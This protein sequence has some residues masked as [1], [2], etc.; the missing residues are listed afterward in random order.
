MNPAARWL[1]P[2]IDPARREQCLAHLHPDIVERLT[3]VDNSDANRGVPASWNV[4]AKTL[5][6]D[7]AAEWLVILSEAIVFGPAG[8]EDFEDSLTDQITDAEWGWHLIGIHRSVFEHVGYF[9]ETFTPGYFEDTDFLYRMHLAGMCSPRENDRPGRNQVT[10]IDGRDLGYALALQEGRVRVSLTMQE[11]KYRHKWG[12]PQ[13]AERFEH[14]YDNPS[15]TW[16]AI[17]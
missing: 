7:P 15:L 16:R 1:L 10:G 12:G 2:S 14:P 8:G 17:R 5:V 11:E 3:L 9:D 4:G 6:T 13:G